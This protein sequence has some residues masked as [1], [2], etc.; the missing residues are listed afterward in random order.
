MNELSAE[1]LV[2][3]L[4]LVGV[5][6]IIAALLSGVIEKSGFPQVAAFLALGAA[7]GPVGLNVLHITIDS[8][9]IHIVSTLSLVLVLFTDAIALDFSE[10]KK[11]GP[12]VLLVLGPGTL[13]SAFLVGVAGW[14]LLGLAPAAAA[15]VGAALASTDPVLLRG[16]LRR[17]EI[18]STARLVLRLESG[19]NDIVLLPIVLVAMVFLDPKTSATPSEW[20]KL[21]LDLLILGPGAGILVGVIGV[22]TL[23]LIRRRIG[24]R[25]DYESIFS[26]GIAF[27]AYA[28]AEAVHGSGFLAAF[29]AGLT[30][31]LLDVELCDCF[32]EYG[33]TTAEMTLLFTFVLFGSALIWSGLGQINGMLILFALLALLVRPVAFLISLA[34]VKLAPRDRLLISWFGPR[35][36]SSLLLILLPVFAGLPG[37]QALFP[38]C[39]LV[40]LFSVVVHGS[41]PMFLLARKKKR[42]GPPSHA[43]SGPGNESEGALYDEGGHD[44]RPVEARQGSGGP[45]SEPREARPRRQPITVP[46][47]SPPAPVEEQ[48]DGTSG[49][50]T[51]MAQAVKTSGPQPS[52]RISID[53]LRDLWKRNAK[54]VILDVRKLR[55]YSASDEQAKGSIRLSPEKAVTDATELGLSRDGW[56]I[57]YCT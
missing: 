23:D 32:L 3:I 57:G 16:L 28:A 21:A 35:G 34:R 4:A 14:G 29:A 44:S 10:I 27:T 19:L 45:G 6:I 51:E 31:S 53:E 22:A 5:V 43:A 46:L 13:L 41:A 17:E 7:L 18:P 2:S 49:V 47:L 40:V 8:P 39:A 38:I 9:S 30:I 24:I 50:Q 56:L 42:R 25:R 52:I 26:L 36:L 54:V 33:E 55:P 15:L 37:S 20:A 12:L 48:R 11:A 1:S